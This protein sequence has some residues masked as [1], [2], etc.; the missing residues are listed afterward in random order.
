MNKETKLY[1]TRKTAPGL[2]YFDKE[3]FKAPE[4]VKQ[5]TIEVSTS[6][7][8]ILSPAV[9]RI[10]EGLGILKNTIKVVKSN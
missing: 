4:P 8:E 10:I 1:A 3:S 5:K 2:R 6:K 9:K 7:K